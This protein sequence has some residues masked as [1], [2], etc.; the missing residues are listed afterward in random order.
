MKTAEEYLKLYDPEEPGAMVLE[1]VKDM[2]AEIV[3][4]NP[5]DGTATINLLVSKARQYNRLWNDKMIPLN[6]D[7]RID[8][9]K[10]LVKRVYSDPKENPEAVR[11]AI[12][13]L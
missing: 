13:Y 11:R 7:L 3:L 2:G 9:F 5:S 12:S 1:M 8:G 10:F 6:D 4:A